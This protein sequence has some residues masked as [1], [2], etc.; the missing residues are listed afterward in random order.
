MALTKASY[1]MVTGA[2]INVKDY[3][4]KGDNSNDDT[5]AIQAAIDAAS[6]NPYQRGAV[7]FP[8][9]YYIITASLQIPPWISMFGNTM[10]GCIINNQTVILNAPQCVAKDNQNIQA[11][12]SKT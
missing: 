5:A 7:Y 11:C 12:K 10:T 2:P 8:D 4:A 9:G 1:S 3:G 6:S